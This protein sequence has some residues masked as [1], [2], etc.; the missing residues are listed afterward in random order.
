MRT[1]GVVDDAV[2]T[3]PPLEG[4]IDERPWALELVVVISSHSHH[5]AEN[6]AWRHVTAFRTTSRPT[7]IVGGP[8]ALQE[9][10]NS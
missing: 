2:H 1:P 6:D 3:R 9:C 4:G 5:V 8:H 7:R 10:L